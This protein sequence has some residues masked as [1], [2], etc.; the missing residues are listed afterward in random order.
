VIARHHAEAGHHPAAVRWYV[1][2]GELASDQF[3]NV[4]AVASYESAV[5]HLRAS[6]AGGAAPGD[7]TALV[8][9]LLRIDRLHDLT[10]NRSAREATLDRLSAL[11]T[12]LDEVSQATILL[13]RSRLAESDADYAEA[14]A[15]AR[16]A[17]ALAEESPR[18]DPQANEARAAIEQQLGQVSWRWSRL[19]EAEE[20]LQRS[21]D[22]AVA[23]G[24]PHI[25]A[26]TTRLLGLV[27]DSHADYPASIEHL[28]RAL[29]LAEQL[30]DRRLQAQCHNS[31]GAGLLDAG[32]LSEVEHHLR[33]SLRIRAE[34]G[35]VRGASGAATTSPSC[36]S[37]AVI[38]SRRSMSSRCWS[39]KARRA[40]IGK[41]TRLR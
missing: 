18:D 40:P 33:E 16:T 5:D 8:D 7:A 32:I 20:H 6:H 23:H 36:C 35:D 13:R 15:L 34:I 14:D 1:R 37:D 17:M 31:L 38:L 28:R 4:D 2:A 26:T 12:Q 22:L 21:I 41:L 10:G 30:G 27:A 9:V 39:P 19:A 3:A 25:E 29:A 24:L 11:V